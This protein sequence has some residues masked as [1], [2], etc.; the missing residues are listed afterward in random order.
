MQ[1]QSTFSPSFPIPKSLENSISNWT[2]TVA[3]APFDHAC[4]YRLSNP[5]GATRYLKMVQRDAD[6]SIADELERLQWAKAFLPVPMI[7][8][9]DLD[10]D[11]AWLLS[12]GIKGNKRNRTRSKS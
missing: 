12:E 6:P 2:T 11:P 3:W 10:A 1:H 4:T 8:D 9:F 7:I 5:N